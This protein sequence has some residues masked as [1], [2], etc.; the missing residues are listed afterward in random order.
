MSDP[1]DPRVIYL[2]GGCFWGVSEFFSRIPGVYS[3]ITG[4]AN[5]KVENPR[6]KQVKAQETDAAETVEVRYDNAVITLEE[7]LHAFFLII[8]PLSVNRQGEDSGRSYRTGVYFTDPKDEVVIRKAFSEVEERLHQKIAVECQRLG[9]FYK[10]EEYHQDYLK[11]N[12][13]GYCHV[14]FA[15]LKIFRDELLK[16]HRPFE[17]WQI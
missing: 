5:S 2:A 4:Y 1:K 3:T 10:A 7:L 13:T 6:Y 17:S 11:K 12:P 14:D 16:D 8:D 15:K 9:N